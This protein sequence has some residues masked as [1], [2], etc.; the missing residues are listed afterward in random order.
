MNQAFHVDKS[1]IY[2]KQKKFVLFSSF[3][4]LAWQIAFEAW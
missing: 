3:F 1:T 2:E 4:F